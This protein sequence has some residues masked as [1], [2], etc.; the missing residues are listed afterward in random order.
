MDDLSDAELAARIAEAAGRIALAVRDSGVVTGGALGVAGDRLTNAF[1]LGA[2]KENRPDDAILS[3]E[4]IDTTERLTRE[5]VWIIDP[6]DGTRE[7]REGRDD[8][9]IHVALAVAGRPACAAV[10][11]PSLEVLLRSDD[12]PP[13]KPAPERLRILVSRT[14]PPIEAERAA[15]AL[16]AELVPMGSAGAKAAAVLLGEGEAYLHAGGQHEWDN[17]APAAIALAAGL[18]AARLDGSPLVYNQA[19]T[20]LPDLLICRPELAPRIG[21]ALRRPG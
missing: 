3:E 18:H 6:L 20:N 4:S 9:A 14:R 11:L 5:R 7:Y 15:A 2:L 16:G 8:W 12:P 21:A 13:L 1:I 19:D 10:C 17:C